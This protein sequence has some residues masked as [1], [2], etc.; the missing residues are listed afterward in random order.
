MTVAPLVL[1][2]LPGP[3]DPGA[4]CDNR[5]FSST[6]VAC[7]D[8]TSWRYSS[9][10]SSHFSSK[11]ADSLISSMSSSCFF[12]ICSSIVISLKLRFPSATCFLSFPISILPAAS[13]SVRSCA[14]FSLYSTS[15]RSRSAAFCAW[16]AARASCKFFTISPPITSVIA[17]FSA[18]KVAASCVRSW[19]CCSKAVISCAT[20]SNR[21]S[22]ASRSDNVASSCPTL[23]TNCW[24]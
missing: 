16:A 4:D 24:V 19:T 23:T 8:F 9:F 21:R 6:I 12:T 1:L 20:L 7:N 18:R 17:K 10:A 13:H 14:S 15:A 5:C 3:L 11:P 2:A 22:W